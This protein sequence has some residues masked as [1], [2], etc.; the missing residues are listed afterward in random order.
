MVGH[1]ASLNDN[2]I[3]ELSKLKTGVAAVYQN[4]WL[5]PVLCYIHPCREDEKAYDPKCLMKKKDEKGIKAAII[6][7]LMLPVPKKLEMDSNK[8]AELEKSVYKL[9]L[10]SDTKVDLMRYFKETEPEKIQRLRNKIVYS[11]FNSEAAIMM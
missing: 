4:D 11:V 10:A 6:D 5:E 7:Y 1:A 9:Q 3:T 2:Q 8:V